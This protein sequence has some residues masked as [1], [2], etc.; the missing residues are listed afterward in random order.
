ME[1]N[2]KSYKSIRF[3]AEATIQSI[4]TNRDWYYESCH[5]CNKAAITRAD[6]YICLDHGPQPNPY[7][8]YKFKGYIADASA[9]ALVTFFTPAADKITGHQCKELVEKYKH[10]NPNKMPPEV[11]AIQGKTSIFQFHFNTQAKITDFTLDDVFNI[12]TADQ[13]TS[14]SAEQRDKGTPPPISIPNALPVIEQEQADKGK[15]NPSTPPPSDAATA[16]PLKNKEEGDK[17]KEKSA[18]RPLFQQ[19]ST[20]PKKQKGD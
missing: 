5:Q 11:L 2:P 19:P 9:T 14:S 10:V 13:S 12:N 16:R 17:T 8:R 18:K 7:L 3:T 1:Q 6:S 20:D 4:N 15:E